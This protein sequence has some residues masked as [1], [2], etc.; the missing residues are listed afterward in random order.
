MSY[1]RDPDSKKRHKHNGHDTI[2]DHVD[3]VYAFAGKIGSNT[4]EKQDIDENKNK[5][6]GVGGYVFMK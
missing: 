3:I 5:S 6:P 2:W 4:N 1:H